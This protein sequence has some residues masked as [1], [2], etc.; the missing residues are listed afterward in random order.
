LRRQIVD[1]TRSRE[2]T[3]LAP[4][5]VHDAPENFVTAQV[6]AIVGVE[7]A[8]ARIK[9]KWKVGRNCHE[10]DWVGVVTRLRET[11]EVAEHRVTR[12]T[13]AIILKIASP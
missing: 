8:T 11:G 7:I 3:R 4:R 5:S 9:G 12:R 13:P 2:G 10:E 6:Q 1:L